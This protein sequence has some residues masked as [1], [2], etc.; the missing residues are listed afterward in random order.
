MS[1]GDG[2]KGRRK[3]GGREE[4]EGE[5]VGGCGTVHGEEKK[6]RWLVKEES[7]QVTENMGGR[8]WSNGADSDDAM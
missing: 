8:G 2:G 1:R 6:R 3:D 4:K 7:T 5:G